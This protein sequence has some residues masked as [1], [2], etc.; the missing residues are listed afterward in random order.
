MLS[1][2]IR[3]LI[4]YTLLLPALAV[5]RPAAAQYALTDL[6]TLDGVA[7][8]S[9]AGNGINAIGQV[10]GWS[11]SSAG[12]RHAFCWTPS[13]PN[14][15]H[16]TL[17][18]FGTLGGNT[19]IAYSINA[20]GR[21]VGQSQTG[22]VDSS[23]NPIIHGF[24]TESNLP[25][26]VPY[27]DLYTLGGDNSAA[28]SISDGVLVAGTAQDATNNYA[29]CLWQG[30]NTLDLGPLTGTVYN[31]SQFATAD[32]GNG[33]NAIGQ[34]V[35]AANIGGGVMHAFLYNG[36][37][38]DLTPSLSGNSA[39]CAIN[40][41][42]LIAGGYYGAPDGFEHAFLWTPSTPNGASGSLAD[43]GTLGG[44]SA[45][46]AI[47]T[48]GQV[49]GE[50]ATPT[51]ESH[52]I[53]IYNGVL[54]D[55]NTLLPGGTGWTLNRA[56]GINDNGQ[57]AGE[58]TGPNG[59]HA[60]L[61][62]PAPVVNSLT[63][64]PTSPVGGKTATGKVTLM[65]AAPSGGALVF[66]TSA[67]TSVATVPATVTVPAGATSVTFTVTTYPVTSTIPVAI[68]MTRGVTKSVTLKVQPVALSS[69]TLTPSTVA[70][71]KSVTGKVTLNGPAPSGGRVITLTNANGAASVPGSVTVPGGA[72]SVS[73]TITTTAVTSSVSGTVTASYNSVNKSVNLTVRPITLKSLTITPASTT[74]GNSVMGKIT[75]EAPAAPGA[76][77]VTLS[78]SN[79]AAANPTLASINI[80]AGQTTVTFTIATSPVSGSTPVTITATANGFSKSAIVTVN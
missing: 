52:A 24:L 74:G 19:S 11:D 32:R 63:F 54:T 29:A 34:I 13:A 8:H 48:F 73:F 78:S 6:G 46:Y 56:Y 70:G 27:D 37:M 66:L 77:T 3:T 20:Y 21:V 7:G 23:G 51:G 36:A 30:G 53:L 4:A 18:D 50:S 80:P 40:A 38:I 31:N 79:P 39:A 47:N 33:I 10:V 58:G 9:S 62:T 42:G 67:N 17:V 72:S 61:L 41:S 57:I 49:V 26:Q 65:S 22:A 25:I 60:F 12:Y 64:T 76:I 69:F 28:F 45:A 71:G 14:A 68:S 5:A 44:F 16:G 59:S 55:L 35:G 15:T 43:L 1:F 75:L 2:R